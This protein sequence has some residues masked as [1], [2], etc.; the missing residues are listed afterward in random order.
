MTES[1]PQAEDRPA[2]QPSLP[3]TGP[4]ASQAL[5]KEDIEWIEK[6]GCENM[7]VHHVSADNLAKDAATTLTVL[8]AGLGGSLAYAAKA[9]DEWHWTNLSAGATAL[10]VW[11]ACLGLYLVVKCLMATPI[12]HIYNE[13]KNFVQPGYT[14]L[15][16][17]EA[18]L[19]NLQKRID[20]A[21][22][23][24]SRLATHLNIAR[25]L[26]VASPIVFGLGVYVFSNFIS[27]AG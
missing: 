17:R 21:A 22:L 10:T 4:T 23:R 13:P 14:V 12:P 8:L 24:N 26:A 18:E 1:T 19:E 2:A 3:L 25:R 27:T 6:V 11:F 9:F 15:E 20:Q 7:K 5:T 16:I